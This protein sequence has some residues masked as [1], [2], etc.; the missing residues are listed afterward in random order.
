[1]ALRLQVTALDDPQARVFRYEF[2]A[3]LAHIT[4]GR[5]GGVD[6]L[7]PHP[8]VSLV[9]ARIERR[10]QDYFLVDDASQAG[11]RL[12]GSPVSSGERVPLRD[13]D[14][15]GIGDFSVIVGLAERKGEWP[16]E[17]S[18][19]LA[20]HM[21]RD[22]L[23]RLG[24]GGSQ[25]SLTVLDGPQTGVVLTLGEVG[26]TFML[27]RAGRGDLRLDDIDVWREHAA[28][29]RDDDGVTIRDLGSAPALKVNGER[30]AGARRLTDG[31]TITLGDSNLRFSDPAEHYLKQLDEA[32]AAEG[33][34]SSPGRRT[35]KAPAIPD[36][37]P[38][39]R[40]RPEVVLAIVGGT[41]AFAGAVA[42]IYVFL[43]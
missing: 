6:V 38:P 29:V 25:P 36:A 10:G 2:D 15:I 7:L 4:L 16:A 37:P 42:L 26:R 27:G 40:G 17:S 3:D 21:A 12:N 1:V 28:L 41:I 33:P 32:D 30:I 39:E 9:H 43:W 13:G 35:G 14:R 23:E 18:G 34:G 31:D 8:R 19:S 20:R 24:P 11:T 5:R 22:L